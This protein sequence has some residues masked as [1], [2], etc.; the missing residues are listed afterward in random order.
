MAW[1]GGVPSLCDE[2]GV[3]EAPLPAG[4][5]TVLELSSVIR[6]PLRCYFQPTT[7]RMNEQVDGELLGP[8]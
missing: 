7:K 2:T 3:G 1:K 5:L 8:T 4:R 6:R